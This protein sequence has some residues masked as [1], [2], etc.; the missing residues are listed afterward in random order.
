MNQSIQDVTKGILKTRFGPFNLYHFSIVDEQDQAKGGSE[1]LALVLGEENGLTSPTLC[2]INSACMTSEV[3]NCQRC[4]CKW[5]LDKAIEMVADK[6]EGIITYH[7]SHEGKGF[8]LASKLRS[9]ELMDEGV[10]SHEVYQSL[11]HSSEDRRDYSTAGLIL[12]YFNI[13]KII[14]LGNN[15][16]KMDAMEKFGIQVVGRFPLVYDGEIKD[17]KNYLHQKSEFPEQ[18]FLK[19]HLTKI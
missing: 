12:N 18:E 10:P 15:K 13:E 7:A 2:R 6:G 5:Q 17:V 1:H 3:F 9:Y 14:M 4:D 8:G 16:N 11:G 19:Q